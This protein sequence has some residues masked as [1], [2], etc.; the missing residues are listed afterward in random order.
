M[1]VAAVASAAMGSCRTAGY[2][3]RWAGFG[4]DFR[5]SATSAVR[6]GMVEQQGWRPQPVQVIADGL[7]AELP[8][9]GVKGRNGPVS[10][11][12]RHRAEP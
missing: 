3:A 12:R 11:G 5:P 10:W 2:S 4:G 6:P 8:Q 1:M 7:R 9:V